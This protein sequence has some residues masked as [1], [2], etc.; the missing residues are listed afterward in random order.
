LQTAS[1]VICLETLLYTISVNNHN[2]RGLC[3]THR[4]VW[5]KLLLQ[6]SLL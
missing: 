2:W 4:I 3:C 1:A 5:Q 6:K